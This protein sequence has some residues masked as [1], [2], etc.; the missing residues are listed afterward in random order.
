MEHSSPTSPVVRQINNGKVNIVENASALD[1]IEL[2]VDGRRHLVQKGLEDTMREI[3]VARLMNQKPG[4]FMNSPI[5][6]TLAPRFAGQEMEDRLTLAEWSLSNHNDKTKILEDISHLF[7]ESRL[8]SILRD[9]LM[10]TADE[11]C[12][13]V[14]FNASRKD[15]VNNL[16]LQ[17][18]VETSKANSL[19]RPALVRV[20]AYKGYLAIACWDG[21]GS[22]DPQRVLNRLLACLRDGP[23]AA[24]NKSEY[25]TAG[26]GS[27][28]VFNACTSLYMA[29]EKNVGTQF[30]A[31]FPLRARARERNARPKH[32]HWLQY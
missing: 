31:L 3:R 17:T 15:G 14:L 8:N 9:D 29:V 20:G 23:G 11:F 5:S 22:L 16:N 19:L 2:A 6:L 7:D 26:I 10:L 1:L 18:T 13:N 25:G 27:F 12:C 28:L 24:L 4:L 21:F 32:L 30:C